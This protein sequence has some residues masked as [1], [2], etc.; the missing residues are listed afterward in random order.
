MKRNI[1][2]I[3]PAA[4]QVVLKGVTIKD[5]KAISPAEAKL[6]D[7]DSKVWVFITNHL[8]LEKYHEVKNIPC[9]KGVWDYLEKIGEGVSTQ[10]D[11]RIDTLQRKFYRFKRN[12]G[13]KVSFIY[14]RLTAL[15]NELISISVDDIIPHSVVRTLL[16][17]L[18]DSFD[19]IVLMIKER[20]DF[21]RLV[22]VDILQRLNTFE[23]VEDEKRDI[24]GSR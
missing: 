18:D 5:E 1:M 4:W 8:T 17:S 6:M 3:N 9:A 21:R 10:K 22:A 24:N 7:L 23:I 20:T 16:R 14:S 13:E 19:H 15:A 2:A 12:E 11:A